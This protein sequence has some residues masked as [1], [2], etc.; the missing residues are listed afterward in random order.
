[1]L[2][3]WDEHAFLDSGIYGPSKGEPGRSGQ[4]PAAFVAMIHTTRQVTANWLG[5]LEESDWNRR[6]LHPRK[7]EQTILGV[8]GLVTWHLEHHAWFLRKKLQLMGVPCGPVP[9]E[10]CGPG[11]GCHGG[12]S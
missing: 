8:L 9:G 7:G 12:D 1:M 6:G 4:P 2:P 11:C 10:A 3:D 5:R